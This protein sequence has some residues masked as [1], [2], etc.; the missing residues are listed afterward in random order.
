M[1]M[2]VPVAAPVPHDRRGTRWW[3]LAVAVLQLALAG[4]YALHLSW[5]L[6]R[7]TAVQD[8]VATYPFNAGGWRDALAVLGGLAWYALVF[9]VPLAVLLAAAGGQLLARRRRLRLSAVRTWL[10]TAGTV[11][12][13]AIVTVGVT[14]F[15]QALAV[16]WLD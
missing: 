12:C 3:S 14:P 16:W 10:L 11:L 1:S 4:L 2:S 7:G 13:L 8:S 15:G 6:N 9:A 5:Y